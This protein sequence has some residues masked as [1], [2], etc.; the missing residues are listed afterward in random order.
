MRPIAAFQVGKSPS[1][2]KMGTFDLVPPL[3]R[4]AR[5]DF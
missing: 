2:L 5:G 1:P 4:G 3:K